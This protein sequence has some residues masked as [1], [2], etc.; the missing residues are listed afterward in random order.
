MESQAGVD[1]AKRRAESLKQT[2]DRLSTELETVRCQL[3]SAN[4][5][6]TALQVNVCLFHATEYLLLSGLHKL[7]IYLTTNHNKKFELMLTRLKI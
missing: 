4:S 6:L 5:Q 3:S 1:A 2:V 7:M